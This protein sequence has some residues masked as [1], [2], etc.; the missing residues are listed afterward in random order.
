MDWARKLAA[1]TISPTHQIAIPYINGAI[2]HW[3]AMASSVGLCARFGLGEYADMAF[4]LHLLRE[5]D[6]FC[7]IGANAGVYTILAAHGARC[8]VIA[9][10][11][12]LGI[13]NLLMQNVYANG[14]QDLVDAR[15]KAIGRESGFLNMTSSL[16]SL[17]HVV[18]ADGDGVVKV[19]VLTLDELMAGRVPTLIKI[20]VEGFEENVLL[21][22]TRTLHEAGLQAILIEMTNHTERYGHTT[23]DIRALLS[24]TGFLGP[25]WYSPNDRKLIPV[26]KPGPTKY[27]EI[28]VRDAVQAAARLTNP[29]RHEIHGTAI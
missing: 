6:L 10:E 25:Y 29:R 17:N 1:I 5:G 11:P 19:D 22:A 4:C 23:K 16:W 14:V 7:D 28:F 27:N 8:K 13:F 2:L 12:I 15:C 18:D 24:N 3:P 26:G 21:G 9:A 20:D